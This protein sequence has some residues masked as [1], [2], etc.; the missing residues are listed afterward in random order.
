MGALKKA[1]K[2]AFFAEK[3]AHA[4][5]TTVAW[6]A[7]TF[8]S[9]AWQSSPFTT[10]VDPGLCAPGLLRVSLYRRLRVDPNLPCFFACPFKGGGFLSE[11]N[12]ELTISTHPFR[13]LP[14]RAND[15]PAGVFI[16]KSDTYIVFNT[17]IPGTWKGD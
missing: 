13:T 5:L 4:I 15:V 10:G 11:K 9:A 12:I 3:K 8:F 6:C 1:Q 2:N 14:L 16:Y 7:F 17:M